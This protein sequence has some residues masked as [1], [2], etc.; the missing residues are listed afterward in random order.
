M[1]QGVQP[2]RQPEATPVGH[3]GARVDIH[4]RPAWAIS[5]WLGVDHRADR[6][7]FP[8]RQLAGDR[9][10]GPYQGRAVL[11]ELCRDRA[12]NRPVVDLAAGGS[13]EPD[14]S[15]ERKPVLLR[16]DPTIHDAL[17]RWSADEFRSLNGITKPA[18]GDR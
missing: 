5:G 4:E 18:A 8:H 1:S 17:A 12:S 16:I 15:R 6:D 2:Y 13:A 3:S 9:A 10:A 11:R 7:R 14:V